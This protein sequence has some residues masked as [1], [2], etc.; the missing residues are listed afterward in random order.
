MKESLDLDGHRPESNDWPTPELRTSVEPLARQLGRLSRKLLR[1]I[2]RGLALTD[3]DFLAKSHSF[4]R[5]EGQLVSAQV[6]GNG[7]V[8]KSE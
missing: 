2:G 5:H 3:P 1:M 8:K 7:G 6:D 4:H